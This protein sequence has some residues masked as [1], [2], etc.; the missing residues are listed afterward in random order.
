ML[1]PQTTQEF[2]KIS[3]NG[4]NPEVS[5]H[6]F[7]FLAVLF[8]TQDSYRWRSDSISLQIVKKW[9][10]KNQDHQ[11]QLHCIAH[12]QCTKTEMQVK[13]RLNLLQRLKTTT[14]KTHNTKTGNFSGKCNLFIFFFYFP[15]RIII[16]KITNTTQ[17][18]KLH[19]VSKGRVLIRSN[20][21]SLMD[22][23]SSSI[24]DWHCNF[25]WQEKGYSTTPK[26]LLCSK[27]T[28]LGFPHFPH[29]QR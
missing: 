24:L 22:C 17:V 16:I 20:R 21:N 3:L 28:Q 2:S 12:C 14:T 27:V 10:G 25:G 15:Q 29:P 23:N 13:T 18:T 19:R 8:P 7:H 26:A 1:L 6:T 5:F 9:K 4:Y 11:F